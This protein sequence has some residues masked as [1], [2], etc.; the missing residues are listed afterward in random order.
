MAD[1]S[2]DS[3]SVTDA[4]GGGGLGEGGSTLK[5]VRRHNDKAAN[6]MGNPYLI[7]HKLL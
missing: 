2:E 4:E 7:K 1:T 3:E 5:I 6:F